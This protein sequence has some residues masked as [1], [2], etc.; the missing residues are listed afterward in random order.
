MDSDLTSQTNLTSEA[1]LEVSTGVTMATTADVNQ[2][3]LPK[4]TW[5][6]T[7][8]L[9]GSYYEDPMFIDWGYLQPAG[10]YRMSPRCSPNSLNVESRKSSGRVSD[11]SSLQNSSNASEN[12]LNCEL[13]ESDDHSAPSSPESSSRGSM[14]S[15]MSE[16]TVSQVHNADKH[17][18]KS[19][20][21][22]STKIDSAQEMFT[23]VVIE[24]Y[25]ENT[26]TE[27][28]NDECKKETNETVMQTRSKSAEELE[29]K[30]KKD[31]NSELGIY[32]STIETANNQNTEVK[33]LCDTSGNEHLS[34]I[35]LLKSKMSLPL[36]KVSDKNYTYLRPR[37]KTF[38]HLHKNGG[39]D[40]RELLAKL[41]D[42]ANH[43]D[44]TEEENTEQ[45]ED[46]KTVIHKDE[47]ME[48]QF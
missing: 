36:V 17:H 44:L 24:K 30:N 7:L 32:N 19:S 20:S 22:D 4:P 37:S 29:T 47:D 23:T 33:G 16:T 9:R 42:I 40:G 38:S 5:P 41:N 18:T 2:Y 45:R 46:L 25:I 43:E 12:N 14:S 27:K 1:G 26:E 3:T 31:T 6:T 13:S 39:I 8:E 10:Q 21:N 11:L 34:R 48:T 15:S 35:A 28:R